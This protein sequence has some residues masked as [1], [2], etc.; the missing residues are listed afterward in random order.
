MPMTACPKATLERADRVFAQRFFC[1]DRKRT[2]PTAEHFSVLGSTGNL[3]TVKIQNLPSCDCPDG[4][5]GNHCKHLVSAVI[6]NRRRDQVDM[7]SP[8]PDC[9]SLS[10]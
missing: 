8:L 6:L 10:S 5:K 7:V 4:A 2:S 3:Y 1:V 9:S